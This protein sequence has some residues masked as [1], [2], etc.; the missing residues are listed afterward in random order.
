MK[1]GPKPLPLAPRLWS[2]VAFSPGCWEWRG[3]VI[4]FT[5]YGRIKHSGRDVRVH[6]LA[7]ELVN[8]PIPAGMC[9][10][11]KCDNRLCVRP[12]HLF[13]GTQL[14]NIAD[15]NAKGRARGPRGDRHPKAKL[16][17]ESA[18][19]IRSL[20]ATG[21]YSQESLAS[22]FG[23]SSVTVH[24]VVHGKRWVEGKIA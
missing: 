16:T 3:N 24:Y 12:D 8:G 18:L 15:M 19:K 20:Y 13:L 11:H 17:W 2:Q 23:V 21:E 7:W 4:Q 14:E 9:V 22:M 6:R 1:P 10:C 5:G